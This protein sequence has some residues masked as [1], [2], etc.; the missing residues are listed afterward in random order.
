MRR[1]LDLVTP[2]RLTQLLLA[3]VILAVAAGSSSVRS[4]IEAT[5]GGLRW[6]VF[7]AFCVSA[8]GWALQRGS[9]RLL[10][11]PARAGATFAGLCVLSAAWSV[12]P[13]TTIARAGTIVLL[14]A[15]AA[16]LAAVAR[17][18]PNAG[19][20]MLLG[21]LA[22]VAAVAV[23]SLLTL[24][25]THANAIQPATLAY[26]AR[27]E[28]FSQNPNT[29]G[30]LLA[31]GL[32]IAVWAATRTGTVAGRTAA[33]ACV[34]LLFGELVATGSRGS[35]V[36]A[37]AAVLVL[38]ATA[39]RPATTRAAL[40]IACAAVFL[41]GAFVSRISGPATTEGPATP[42]QLPKDAELH[43]PQDAEVG[44][45]TP[46]APIQHRGLFSSSGRLDAWRGAI[47]QANERPVAGYG[48][49]TEAD[50][51]VDRY[52][53][54]D[55]NLVEN[56]Y[57]GLDLQLGIA[58]LLAFITL[59]VSTVGPAARDRRRGATADVCLAVVAAGV[60]LAVGQSFVY[61][62]G[63]TAAVP[64]WICVFLANAVRPSTT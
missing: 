21:V 56:S 13:R 22:G 11:S 3:L 32:P 14:F 7:S 5:R 52:Y 41:A 12:E 54:L 6:A 34:L 40:A 48:F 61:A 18:R 63:A 62:V 36:A 53:G 16:A 42:T 9:L 49:G 2:E 50:V 43:L 30:M 45:P 37:L 39:P 28:G 1:T 46:G 24:A 15:A 33:G 29:L 8:V 26:G 51:F 44:A 19:E 59:L 27:F 4:V 23:A 31:V 10:G 64:F 17:E 38:A 35:L 57:I 55:S 25:F 60:V 47:R 58:G 20:A